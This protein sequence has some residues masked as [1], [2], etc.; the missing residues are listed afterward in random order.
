MKGIK[1]LALDSMHPDGTGAPK[2]RAA[3]HRQKPWWSDDQNPLRCCGCE[4]SDCSSFVIG[5]G[6][7]RSRRIT[8]D[9]GGSGGD[10]S[11]QTFDYGQSV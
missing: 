4:P 10:W 3:I 9:G 8:V 2:K 1:A 11:E 7:G 6:G 5:I